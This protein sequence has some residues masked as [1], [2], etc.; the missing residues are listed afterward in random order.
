MVKSIEHLPAEL[1]VIAFEHRPV[2]RDGGIYRLDRRALEHILATFAEGAYRVGGECQW[3]EVMGQPVRLASLAHVKGLSGNDIPTVT[4]LLGV[5]VVRTVATVDRERKA[6]LQGHDSAELPAPQNLPD[7]LILI[8]Q[9]WRGVDEIA[10][11][12]EWNV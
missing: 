10:D 1:Q 9:C 11:P 3:I 8:V 6:G 5:G 2:L 12:N 7:K 4:S